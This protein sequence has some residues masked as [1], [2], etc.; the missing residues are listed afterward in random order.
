[1]GPSPGRHGDGCPT[2]GCARTQEAKTQ[3]TVSRGP[4]ETL[5]PLPGLSEQ[6]TKGFSHSV[7]RQ[8]NGVQISVLLAALNIWAGIY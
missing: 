8:R 6:R 7:G 1:M 2:A 3:E 5:F 4:R